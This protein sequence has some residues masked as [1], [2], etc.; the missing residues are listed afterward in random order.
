MVVKEV[1]SGEMGQQWKGRNA[2]ERIVRGMRDGRGSIDLTF[3]YHQPE[4]IEYHIPYSGP[5]L[6]VVHIHIHVQYDSQAE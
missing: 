1:V 3:D 4:L 2:A 6:C 5:L